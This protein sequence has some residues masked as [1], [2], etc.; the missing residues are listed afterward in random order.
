MF[1]A[2]LLYYGAIAVR[3]DAIL[4]LDRMVK[5]RFLVENRSKTET[6]LL[7]RAAGIVAIFIEASY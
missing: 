6:G 7:L 3:S 1:N 2:C 4:A 5:Q